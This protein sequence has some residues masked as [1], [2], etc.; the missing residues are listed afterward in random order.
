MF[1]FLSG[2]FMFPMSQAA[3][4]AIIFLGWISILIGIGMIIYFHIKTRKNAQQVSNKLKYS[5]TAMSLIF[6]DMIY[7]IFI[8]CNPLCLL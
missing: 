5:T 3:Y 4:L 1:K 2:L 6:L 8:L 7:T